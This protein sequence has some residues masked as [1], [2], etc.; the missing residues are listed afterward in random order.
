ME[1]DLSEEELRE[2]DTERQAQAAIA[3]AEAGPGARVVMQGI[4]AL[5]GDA[6]KQTIRSTVRKPSADE[7][8]PSN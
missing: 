4:A 3:Q 8:K 1:L 7:S 5:A 2:R 6:A